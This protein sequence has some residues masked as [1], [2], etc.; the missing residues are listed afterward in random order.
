[1]IRIICKKRVLYTG[2]YDSCLAY[3]DQNIPIRLHSALEVMQ[4]SA[5]FYVTTQIDRHFSLTVCHEEKHH[6]QSGACARLQEKIVIPTHLAVVGGIT[7]IQYRCFC[8]WA[9][10]KIFPL[11]E[12]LL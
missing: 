4:S 7:V 12:L 10:S 9:K 11:Y 5:A 8:R 3:G 1:M 2:S 6:C